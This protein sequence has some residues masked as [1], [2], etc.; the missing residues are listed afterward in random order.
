M[1]RSPKLCDLFFKE[2]RR[3]YEKKQLDKIYAES[4]LTLR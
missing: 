1:I 4:I 2:E 3:V